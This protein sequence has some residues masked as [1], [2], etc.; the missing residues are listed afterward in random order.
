MNNLS[1]HREYAKEFSAWED[2][3]AFFLLSDLN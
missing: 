1:L 2:A 3:V